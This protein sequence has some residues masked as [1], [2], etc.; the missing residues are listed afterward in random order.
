MNNA[1]RIKRFD[2]NTVGNDYV[3]GDIHGCFT[4]LQQALDDIGFNPEVDRLFSVGDL[5]DRGPESAKV[6]EW[7]QKPWFHP[8]MG[9]HEDMAIRFARGNDISKEN[10]FQNGGAWLMA[11]LKD[12]QHEY[13]AALDEL[14]Y[15][16]EVQTAHGVVGI[17]HADI[18]GPSWTGFVSTLESGNYNRYFRMGIMWN[19]ERIENNDHS[20]VL[21]VELL[22]VGHTP[23]I[24]AARLGNV[25][26]IDTVGW[27]PEGYFS[28]VK[29]TDIKVKN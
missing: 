25:L 20:G 19:R 16:I 26:Y 10:Y 4:R 13:G 9:N 7:L 28:I 17:V 12:A 29:L 27:R 21:D 15:A 24:H 8:V 1:P 18:V 14:P 11:M 5:V 22:V 6:L 3:V 23:V 2:R